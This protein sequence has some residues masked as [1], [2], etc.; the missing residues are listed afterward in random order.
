MQVVAGLCETTVMIAHYNWKWWVSFPIVITP[1]AIADLVVWL[2][3][4]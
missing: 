3:I 2:I 1:I 4:G